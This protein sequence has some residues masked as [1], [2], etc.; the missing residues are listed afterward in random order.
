M[1]VSV[2]YQLVAYKRP[3]TVSTQLQIFVAVVLLFEL[4]VKVWI[5]V[6][7]TDLGYQLAKAREQAVQ[8]DMRKRELEL[9]LSMLMRPDNLEKAAGKKLGLIMLDPKQAKRLLY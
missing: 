4:I 6:Q 2:D 3:E 1:A 5:N 9:E 8:Y 7:T